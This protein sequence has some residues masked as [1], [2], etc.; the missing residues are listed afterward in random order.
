ML[1]EC[2]GNSQQTLP[3]GV[4]CKKC[5]SYFGQK[6]EP[7]LLDDPLFHAIAV[8]LALVDPDDMNVFRNKIFDKT[9]V[10]EV[11]PTRDL[12]LAVNLRSGDLV[13]DIGYTIKGR[14]VRKYSKRDL[15]FLSRAIHKIAFESL[16]W[17]LFVGECRE[18]F[19]LFSDDFN[20]VRSWAREGQPYGSVR[21]VLRKPSPT[22]ARDFS[23]TCWK[24]G[25]AVGIELMLFADWYGVT[26]TSRPGAALADLVGWLG[27]NA[28][29]KT[30]C[31]T[32]ELTGVQKLKL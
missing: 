17:S 5:N 24:F 30:C 4:V 3:V 28:D 16:A 15:G 31:I 10:P 20:P 18:G 25:S 21:P 12:N 14:L 1:P 9:H 26:L 13:V 6:I 11:P 8:T 7:V 29:E 32:D 19:D 27:P 22:F 23:Q 2:A